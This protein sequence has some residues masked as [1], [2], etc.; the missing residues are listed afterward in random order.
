MDK[1]LIDTD[2]ILDFFLDRTPYADHAAEVLGLSET[3]KIN[4]YV[5]PVM[6]SNC[7]Y[8]LR[9]TAKHDKVVHS[10]KLLLTIVDVVSMNQKAVLN[11]L[12]SKFKDLED[13]LQHFSA[14]NEE[15]IKIILTR[16]VKDYKEST[17]AVMTPE[18]YLKTIA[19]N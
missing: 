3:G 4:A 5:T 1:V 2:V 18:I 13:A 19:N 11:A 14:K 16:N 17:I 6:I 9:K 10:L 7:Y 15:G 8:I 12:N